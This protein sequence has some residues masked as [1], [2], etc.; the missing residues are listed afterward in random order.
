MPD[1]KLTV[2]TITNGQHIFYLLHLQH[3]SGLQQ[4]RHMSRRNVVTWLVALTLL[5]TNGAQGK[6]GGRGSDKYYIYFLKYEIRLPGWLSRYRNSLRDGCL[7][8]RT[9]VGAR[10]SVH[11][12]PGPETH[13]ASCWKGTDFLPG[14]HSTRCVAFAAHPLL[15]PR[16]KKE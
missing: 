4:K 1:D 15:V 14:G 10:F 7:G 12:Q 8:V 2:F 11:V 3:V 6:S 13:M 9:P 5:N 16:L